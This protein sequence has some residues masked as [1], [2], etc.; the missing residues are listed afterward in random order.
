MLVI[1]AIDLLDGDVVRLVRGNPDNKVI[2]GS[3]PV[4]IAKK[5]E[6]AGADMLHVVDLDATLRTGRKNTEIVSTII[7]AVKIPVEVAGGIRSVPL[8]KE[9]FSKN[10]AKVVIGTMA[11]KNPDSV[12]QIAKKNQD[13]IVISLDQYN[14]TIMVDGWRETTG[15]RVID[16]LMFF[17]NMGVK[18]FL[19]TSVDRDGTMT[20][21]DIPTLSSAASVTSAKI[22][23]SGGISSIEDA[24]KVKN[25][26]CSGVILGKALYEGKINVERVKA[27]S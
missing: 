20:G 17:M 14:G 26:G 22:I 9:F 24:I 11:Y 12:K 23:A 4:Q 7:N 2:Y 13:R 25:V 8:V 5:W 10:A 19:L 21:P 16:S 1:P 18:E 15:S 3:D 27:I 6:I